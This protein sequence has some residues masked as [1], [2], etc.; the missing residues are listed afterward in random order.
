MSKKVGINFFLKGGNVEGYDP[1]DLA[2]N[3]FRE[4]ED[5]YIL[6]LVYYYEI[7]KD[8]VSRYELYELCQTCGCSISNLINECCYD[9]FNKS[10]NLKEISK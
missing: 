2:F 5:K 9:Q 6:D 8:K 10:N 4:T 1:V 7:P 3:E